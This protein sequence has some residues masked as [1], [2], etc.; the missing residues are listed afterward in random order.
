MIGAWS[1]P[2]FHVEWLIAAMMGL[3]VALGAAG[4]VALIEIHRFDPAPPAE[5]GA[6]EWG[7]PRP[8]PVKSAALPTGSREV[9]SEIDTETD[10]AWEEPVVDVEI[11]GSA[12][13]SASAS[14]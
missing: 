2:P 14:E 5:A 6:H 13:V 12:S 1:V 7:T 11:R 8:K 3:G 9:G 10:D 4:A